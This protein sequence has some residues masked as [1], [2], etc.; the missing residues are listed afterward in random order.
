MN[1]ARWLA[2]RREDARWARE[3]AMPWV[4]RRL[5]GASSGDGLSAKRPELVPLSAAG[6]AAGSAADESDVPSPAGGPGE[7]GQDFF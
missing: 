3:Y 1:W 7:V 6:S 4:R 2:A 5:S